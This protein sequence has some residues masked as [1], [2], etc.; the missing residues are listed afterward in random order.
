[1]T[2]FETTT[3]QYNQQTTLSIVTVTQSNNG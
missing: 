3:I 2:W 1:L